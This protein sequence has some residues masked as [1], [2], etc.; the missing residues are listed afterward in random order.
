[1]TSNEKTLSSN[2][3]KQ[4]SASDKLNDSNTVQVPDEF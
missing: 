2:N 4:D 1:M 3:Y